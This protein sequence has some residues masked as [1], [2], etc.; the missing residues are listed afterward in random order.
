MRLCLSCAA[1]LNGAGW[2]CPRCGLTPPVVDGVTILAPDFAKG[3]PTDA[4]Y[5]H[6]ELY[7][8]EDRHFWFTSRSRLIAW[9]IERYFPD[10]RSLFDAGCGT[11][12]VLAALRTRLPRVH[13]AAGDALLAG[14][15]FARRRLPEIA[16][17]QIDLR[18]LPYDREFDLVGMFDVLEHLDEDEDAL[19]EMFRS[20]KP[21]GGLIVTVPQ[22]QFLWSALDEYSHHRRRYSRQDLVEK[23]SRAGYVIQRAT[24]FMSVTLPL[25]FAS[26]LRQQNVATLDPA[27]EMRLNPVINGAL[28][29]MCAVERA[30]IVSGVSFPVGGSLLVVAR[31]P[32]L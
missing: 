4:E 6:E 13:F 3:N 7:A 23:I 5:V 17:V 12:G 21:G 26:R 2:A 9:A 20:T 10:A 19:R 31:R 27:A 25:Q 16:F 18:R 24:S 22:H 28:R 11:G 15:A 14:L 8:A 1:T 30:A 29:A 32:S